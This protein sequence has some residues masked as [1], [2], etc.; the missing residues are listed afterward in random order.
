MQLSMVVPSLILLILLGGG[1]RQTPP[2]APAGTKLETVSWQAAA[3]VLKDSA[4]VVLPLGGG[5]VPYGPHLPLGTEQRITDYL[6]RR[7]LDT[8]DVVVAPTL[9]YHHYPAFVEYPGSTSLS[10]NTARDVIAEAVR[11]LARFGPRRFYVLNVAD[12]S[13]GP[14]TAAAALLARDGLVLRFTDARSRLQAAAQAV[15]RQ[16]FGNHADEID[17]SMMLFIDA[18]AVDT[19]RAPTELGQE[20]VP[21][22][23]TR[24]QGGRGTYSPSGA[25]GDATRATREK[26]AVLIEALLRAIRNDLEDL[27]R[28]QPPL[29][30][31]GAAGA[32]AATAGQPARPSAPGD[33]LP[34]DD[35]TIRAIAPAFALAWANQDPLT[36]SLL[37]NAEGDMVHP[38]GFVE[39]TAQT[40]RENRAALFMRPEYRG[41]KHGLYFGQIRCI[42]ADVAVADARWDLRGVVDGRGGP[43]PNAEGLCTLVLRRRAG[44]WGIEA[45]RYTMKPTAGAR[46]PTV[47]NRPGFTD[48]I[49]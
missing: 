15:R 17:T 46:Q 24:Q 5:A 14:L 39:R 34:G 48:P 6:T 30:G 33:C 32:G 25:W 37:W 9:T 19:A 7:I 44:G 13:S 20:S 2:P 35:R 23:L 10:S 26:G 45:Y 28:T 36:L 3:D 11:S 31:A 41:S 1:G 43:M 49:R 40:I 38:D 47:L 21:F 18:S 42:T 22:H 27:R 29:P 12:T 8:V 16:P 4:V